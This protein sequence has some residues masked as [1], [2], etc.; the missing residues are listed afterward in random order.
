MNNKI[1]F[2]VFGLLIGASVSSQNLLESL[3]KEQDKEPFKDE[4]FGT[5]FGSRINL[6]HSVETRE[7]GVLEVSLQNRFWNIPSDQ[8]SF[9]VDKINVRL[10]ASYAFTDKFT[11]GVGYGTGYDSFDAFFKYSILKQ[12]MEKGSPFSITL[13][14]SIAHRQK[15]PGITR[16]L[17]FDERIG[18]TSQVLIARKLSRNFSLQLMPTFTNRAADSFLPETPQSSRFSLGFG[19]RYR[20]AKHFSLT[21]E[22][23]EI[24]NRIDSPQTY[25][26]FSFGANWEIAD[27]LLQ[28]NVTNARNLVEDKFIAKSLQPFVL[29]DGDL[30]VGFNFVYLFHTREK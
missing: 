24:F 27:V 3:S 14:Q 9:D 17:D 10:E 20:I 22:Y 26:P 11:I 8:L 23:Y 1:L 12:K 21:A 4:V 16:P 6:S 2:S 30:H 13:L 5:F 25:S 15:N 18:L 19:G 28:F 7:Q 29:K